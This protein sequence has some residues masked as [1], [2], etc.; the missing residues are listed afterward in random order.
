MDALLEHT[1]SRDYNPPGFYLL[2]KIWLQLGAALKPELA[3][4]LL[5]VLG[6]VLA[7]LAWI[8]FVTRRFGA[9]TGFFTGALYAL[10]PLAIEA[11]RTGRPYSW[12][13]LW[14]V[15]VFR[16]LEEERTGATAATRLLGFAA[17][18]AALYTHYTGWF[19][20][21]AA[22][23]WLW[24][25]RASRGAWVPLAAMMA[26]GP[27]FPVFQQHFA[28]GNPYLSP[29]T[30]PRLLRGL[31]VLLTGQT[32]FLNSPGLSPLELAVLFTL[33]GFG[34]LLLLYG[35]ADTS[36]AALRLYAWSGLLWWL[37]VGVSL[38]RPAFEEFYLTPLVP[39]LCVLLARGILQIA[40]LKF[41]AL[42]GAL[43]YLACVYPIYQYVHQDWRRLAREIQR[44]YQPG[45]LLLAHLW[46]DLYPLQ[47]YLRPLGLEEALL[48]RAD[49]PFP[50]VE[51]VQ[52]L[53]STCRRVLLAGSRDR[54][55]S[56]TPLRN[57]LIQEAPLEKLYFFRSTFLEIH[58]CPTAKPTPPRRMPAADAAQ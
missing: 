6:D 38:V 14:A 41:V 13:V 27:W 20:L 43:L 54:D 1:I 2:A 55:I 52:S 21:A 15:L 24:F 58:A 57:L 11:A 46:F 37:P 18:T 9:A 51:E 48:R 3:L 44:Q 23:L 36:P 39:F 22:L 56:S 25:H 30:A 16:W 12:M 40:D 10:H 50:T 53:L 31:L 45:D 26:F 17:L 47:F 33:T 42:Y 34:G 32:F 49:E 28:T 4:R 7:F 35:L 8:P 29:L 19:L 5:G